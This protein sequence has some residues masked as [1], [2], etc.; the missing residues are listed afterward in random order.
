MARNDEINIKPSLLD[1]LLDDEPSVSQEPEHRRHHTVQQL[2][3]SVARD[4][5]A[6]LNTRQEMLSELPEEFVELNQALVTYGLPDFTSMNLLSVA[7]RNRIRR[8]LENTVTTF[9]PRLQNVRVVIEDSQNDRTL[10]F[11]IEAFLHVEPAAESVT[12]DAVLRL[13][14]KEYVI[15]GQR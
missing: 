13:T 2:K 3:K 11:R 15:Q 14:T 4:L 10:R 5:E 8:S 1:R 7:D 6:L 9:E 12:F